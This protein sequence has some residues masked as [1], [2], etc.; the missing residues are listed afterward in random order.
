MAGNKNEMNRRDVL[1]SFGLGA[2]G[3]GLGGKWPTPAVSHAAPPSRWVRKD[4]LFRTAP[5]PAKVCLVKGNNR[6]DIVYQALKKIED[7]VIT[8]IGEKK[9]L[10]KPK[11]K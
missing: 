8:S 11:L 1:R 7:E 10:I 4:G 5:G 2:L 9:I 3:L 6:R